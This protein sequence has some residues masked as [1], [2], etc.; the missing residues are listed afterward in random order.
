[1]KE[2]RFFLVSNTQESAIIDTELLYAVQV[3]DYVCAFYQE[4]KDKFECTKSLSE[5]K[6][7]AHFYQI[8]RSTII[9]IHK[10]DK[11]SWQKREV[12]FKHRETQKIFQGSVRRFRQLKLFLHEHK[13]DFL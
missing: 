9:N 10:I 2:E 1:M 12:L 7:P 3:K 4:G 6:L 8:S 11:V 13:I 5:L